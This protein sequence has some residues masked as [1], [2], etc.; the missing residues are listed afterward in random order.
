M[1]G[2]RKARLSKEHT[3]EKQRTSLEKEGRGRREV[4]L[5]GA[6][7]FWGGGQEKKKFI[8]G[9][10]GKKAEKKKG[11]AETLEVGPSYK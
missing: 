9:T 4:A 6:P 1:G 2:L 5:G 3:E 7:Q 11:P 10:I 8:S